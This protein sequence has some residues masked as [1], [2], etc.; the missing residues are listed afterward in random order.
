MRKRE[1][2]SEE[3]KVVLVAKEGENIRWGCCPT[4]KF[5]I[6]HS[7]YVVLFYVWCVIEIWDGFVIV[8]VFVMNTP[9]KKIVLMMGCTE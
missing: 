7:S 6:F 2:K 1:R 5:L 4:G 3:S 8:A 9:K